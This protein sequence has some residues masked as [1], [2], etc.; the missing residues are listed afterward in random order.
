[1]TS[2]GLVRNA[3]V[4]RTVSVGFLFY[5]MFIGTMLMAENA[6]ASAFVIN[7]L[8]SGGTLELLSDGPAQIVPTNLLA[9]SVRPT[10]ADGLISPSATT[11]SS[12]NVVNDLAAVPV[13][14]PGSLILLGSGLALAA[15]WLRRRRKVGSAHPPVS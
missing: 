2:V 11:L 4:L 12:S 10:L 8:A 9:D 1:M 13:P 6:E 3:S 7:L 15:R 14:E 5:A